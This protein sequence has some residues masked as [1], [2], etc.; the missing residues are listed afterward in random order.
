MLFFYFGR[1]YMICNIS[2]II[3]LLYVHEYSLEGIVDK[4]HRKCTKLEIRSIKE[5]F[6]I[7]MIDPKIIQFLKSMRTDSIK[8]PGIS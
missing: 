3:S 8:V 6:E 2:H 7:N 1:V 4:L 5:M